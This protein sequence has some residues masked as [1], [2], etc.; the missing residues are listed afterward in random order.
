MKI[1]LLFDSSYIIHRNLFSL[2]QNPNGRFLAEKE[3]QSLFIKKLIDDLNSIVAIFP[4]AYLGKIVWAQDS[5][6]WRKDLIE[7]ISYKGTRVKDEEKVDW[8]SFYKICDEF[9][10]IVQEC[11]MIK[12]R[13]GRAE[14]DDLLY[15]WSK[16]FLENGESSIIITS[17]RDLNQCVRYDKGNLVCIFNPVFKSKKFTFHDDLSKESFIDDSAIDDIFSAREDN[18][19]EKIFKISSQYERDFVDPHYVSFSKIFEG[20][21][22]DNIPSALQWKKTDRNGTEKIFS[23]TQKMTDQLSEQFSPDAKLIEKLRTDAKFREKIAEQAILISK[24][25]LEKEYTAN[26]I[27]ENITLVYLH[28]SVIPQDIAIGNLDTPRVTFDLRDDRVYE[29]KPEWTYK[30]NNEKGIDSDIFSLFS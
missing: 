26:R 30:S 22:G 29:M 10:D 25:D 5:K 1:N 15:L 28:D 8:E 27:L 12:S 23:F 16:H 18:I 24:Q 19:A 7:K 13:E 4:R 21:K 20:D 14:A 3:E 6:S 2:V 17:D 11:G 9:A